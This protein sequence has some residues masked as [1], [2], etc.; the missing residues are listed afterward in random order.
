VK[1]LF[2]IFIATFVA[3]LTALALPAAPT[4]PWWAHA[5]TYEIYPRSFADSN[6]DGVG[7]LNGVTEHLDYLKD[8][9][10]DAIWI[11]PMFPS[12]QVDFGYDISDYRSVDPQFG[13]LADL[14]RLQAEAKRR[15]IHLIL[16]LVLNHT[17]DRHPWFIESAGSRDNPRADWYVWS[18]G[19]P[20]DAP[21]LAAIQKA[22]AVDGRVPPNNWTSIFGGSAWEWV[23]AR[24]QFY[25][26]MFYTQQ[27]DLNWRNPE[28]ESAMFDV[29]RFWLDR[30][31]DGF[32]LDA[33]QTIYED[34]QRRDEPAVERPDGADPPTTDQIVAAK[35]HTI[36]Q[37]GL[38][39]LMRRMR[40]LV[41][42]YPEN[43]VLIGEIYLSNI[44]ELDRWY[45]GAA[46]DELQQ[47]MNML[48]GFR[49]GAT[50]SATWFRTAMT[51]SESGLHGSM[52]LFV[53]DNHD[54]PRSIDR[55]GDGEHDAAIA[56][57][58]AAVLLL[59]RAA[60][61]TYYGAEIGMRTATPA[62]REDVRDPIGIVGWPREKGRDG[63]RT[64]MQWTA[65]PQAGFSSHAKTWL[66]VNPDHVTVN[67]A[68]ERADP[69]SL[70]NWNRHLIAL[71]RT[72]PALIDGETVMLDNADPDVLVFARIAP[73]ARPVIAAI[74]MSAKPRTVA[75]DQTAVGGG[76]L[77]LLAS[78]DPRAMTETDTFVL[79]PFATIV[80]AAVRVGR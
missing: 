16:D 44:A 63:E 17:S 33:I 42:S 31:I 24:K 26:H 71:R 76:K 14:D 73:G 21:G 49:H 48:I 80:A 6:G 37:P 57:G 30:G 32:R 41:D 43:R 56:K 46:K 74:N 11:A 8:F 28:V 9:G 3:V 29:M 38:H 18:D 65:G 36:D 61:L 58:L 67:V 50:Y 39:G 66:P 52:P 70:Y 19:L 15:G 1:R 69:T 47:P 45:G 64:P 10:V 4:G 72:E 59:P 12:P 75:V 55:F 20:D 54:N 34:P 25:Y 51:Q 27:P 35:I 60:A 68:V 62:R 13:T 22:S 78:S 5:L 40:A 7:D 23:P 2:S 77:T 53:F 79:P